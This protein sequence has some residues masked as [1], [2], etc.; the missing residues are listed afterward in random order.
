V[1]AWDLQRRATEAALKAVEITEETAR[2]ELRA[3]VGTSR[4]YFRD[5]RRD[6]PISVVV[7]IQNFGQTPA[8]NYRTNLWLEV[9]PYP[10]AGPFNT[11]KVTVSD[12]TKVSCPATRA[13]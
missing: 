9:S 5:F 12:S 4:V 7:E 6:R 13:S 10:E 2:R 1:R 11:D 3:Y 8:Y